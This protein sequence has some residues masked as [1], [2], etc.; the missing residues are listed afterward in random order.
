MERDRV[1]F[2][3]GAIFPVL[4]DSN[5]SNS[6]GDTVISVSNLNFIDFDNTAPLT[7]TSIT[8]GREGITVRFLGDGQT[9]IQNNATIVT[10]TGANKLLVANRV[11][12]FTYWA[13]IWYEDV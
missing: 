10:N 7:V 9:T 12:R 13:G 4:P 5:N 8:G 11:Y 2:T 6:S 3:G 1:I